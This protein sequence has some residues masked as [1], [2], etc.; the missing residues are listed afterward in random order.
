MIHGTNKPKL[1]LKSQ[2]E[3]DCLT[4]ARQRYFVKQG[5]I[6]KA[7]RRYAKRLRRAG[8]VEIGEW[9]EDFSDPQIVE[10]LSN[11]VNFLKKNPPDNNWRERIM[12]IGD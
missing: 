3:C 4:K 5:E 11:Y 2:E 7:K 6:R 10:G 12:T 9:M 8:V 1:L